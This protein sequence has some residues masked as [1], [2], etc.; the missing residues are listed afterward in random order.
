MILLL[1][2]QPISKWQKC[3]NSLLRSKTL[4]HPQSL[5]TI[6]TDYGLS[7]WFLS[8]TL[9]PWLKEH[10][11][12][13]LLSR[14][15]QQRTHT[16][17]LQ[18]EMQWNVNMK[19]TRNKHFCP[20]FTWCFDLKEKTWRCVPQ[21]HAMHAKVSWFI[22]YFILHIELQH[23]CNCFVSPMCYNVDKWQWHFLCV[24]AQIALMTLAFPITLCLVAQQ[25][26]STTCSHTVLTYLPTV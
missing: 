12:R 26:C 22:E 16:L 19:R 24:I 21:K 14:L 15:D 18:G 25:L 17:F 13:T 1:G 11:G 5:T 7:G 3:F 2:E 23:M 8:R 6:E 9:E 20:G 4:A 10:P